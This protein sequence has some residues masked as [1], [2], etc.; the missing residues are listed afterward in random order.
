MYA[1]RS[2]KRYWNAVQH[3]EK[4]KK[5]HN[6]KKMCNKE[7]VS[8][9]FHHKIVLSSHPFGNY[10][11]C[12]SCCFDGIA[13]HWNRRFV[14]CCCCCYLLKRIMAHKICESMMNV[15]DGA[16]K[17]RFIF[18]WELNKKKQSKSKKKNVEQ[19]AWVGWISLWLF[20]YDKC[21]SLY[22]YVHLRFVYVC[23]LS[24][25]GVSSVDMH[26]G[27]VLEMTSKRSEE[28]QKMKFKVY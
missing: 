3:D 12:L 26:I 19:V 25:F 9:Y 15:S 11:G 20:P 17:N 1:F 4:K 13:W 2:R 22:I 16:K 24:L 23:M 6:N 27:H 10:D 14:D 18:L 7:I 21:L 28:K 8:R 5:R